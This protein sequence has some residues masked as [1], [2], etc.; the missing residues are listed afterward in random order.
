MSRR[1]VPLSYLLLA[2]VYWLYWRDAEFVLDDW[3]Q[4]QFY[5]QHP[6]WEVLRAL[7]Q[8]KLYSIFQLFWL[9]CWVDALAVL[10]HVINAWLLYQL[11]S[12]LRVY[13]RMAW[14]AGA[15]FV[16]IPTAHGPLFW[17]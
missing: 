14:L 7:L 9:S 2:S 1:V 10:V 3:F 5:R 4:F 15:L 13:P 16:L 12:R 8:N 17:N 6:L 11:A